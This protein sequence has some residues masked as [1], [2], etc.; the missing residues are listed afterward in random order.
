[1]TRL[2]IEDIAKLAGV[3][4]ATVSRAIHSPHK[5]RAETRTRVYQLF[6]KHNY[7]YNAAA[8]DLSRQKSKVIGLLVPTT[9]SPVFAN[10]VLAIQERCQDS[11]YSVI[12]GNTQYDA[13]IEEQLIRQFQERRVAGMILTGFTLG[14]EQI[15]LDLIRTGLP[16]IVIWEKLDDP[17]FNYIGFDNFQTA[18]SMTD[19]LIKLGHKRIGLIMG[20]YSKMGRVRKRLEGFRTAMINQGIEIDPGLIIEKEP[21]LQNGE[22]ALNQLLDHP[23]RPTAVFA[24]SDVLAIGAI[25]A[26]KE[27]GLKV[28]QDIS[29]AGHD[30]IDFAAYTDPPLTTVRVAGYEI[31]RLAAESLLSKIENSNGPGH[32]ICLEP[33]LV[34]RQSCCPKKKN[35]LKSL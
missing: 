28:P 26:A 16:I 21:T 9:R 2:S 6:E 7:I 8:A 10:S 5:V 1:L 17:M 29:I 22:E 14:L 23:R 27:R 25:K 33:D 11:G 18:Y 19:Y 31:G 35:K 32:R 20:P 15:V 3:S 4:S 30:D 34:I 24:A 12:L 13:R